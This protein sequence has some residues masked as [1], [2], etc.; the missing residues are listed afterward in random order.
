MIAFVFDYEGDYT[1]HLVLVNPNFTKCGVMNPKSFANEL[2]L[3]RLEIAE[4]FFVG[5]LGV[6]RGQVIHRECTNGWW[7]S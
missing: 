7:R 4:N 2:T 5:G 3:R 6:L 1:L